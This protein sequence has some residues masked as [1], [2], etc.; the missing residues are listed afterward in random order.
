MKRVNLHLDDALHDAFKRACKTKK[1]T[2]QKQLTRL[3]K[4]FVQTHMN[5]PEKLSVK[6]KGSRHAP[7]EFRLT[8][9]TNGD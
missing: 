4:K 7:A 1:R 9:H 6:A 3:V 2:L 5:E 8:R